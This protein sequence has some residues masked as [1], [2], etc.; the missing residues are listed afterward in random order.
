VSRRAR[1]LAAERALAPGRA[2]APVPTFAL[3]QPPPPC[4]LCKPCSRG[5]YTRSDHAGRRRPATRR[6]RGGRDP[7]RRRRKL[8]MTFCTSNPTGADGRIALSQS[9]RCQP[10]VSGHERSGRPARRSARRG[11]KRHL[12]PV[13]FLEPLLRNFDHLL[14]TPE[15]IGIEDCSQRAPIALD[16]GFQQL[17]LVHR[18][19][20]S[21]P[22]I[23]S[24]LPETSL[25]L[26][27]N[28]P[29]RSRWALLL[30]EKHITR[31]CPTGG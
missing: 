30:V 17:S 18:R 27:G 10:I 14:E 16:L 24:F 2:E 20:T 25:D 1:I 8:A 3:L 23:G 15:D 19:Q 9:G 31:G 11:R 26:L 6:W 21:S 22:A 29:P 7:Q 5:A 13:D 12:K 28:A 4:R